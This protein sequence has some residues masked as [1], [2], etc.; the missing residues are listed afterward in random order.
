[1]TIDAYEKATTL[2]SEIENAKENLAYRERLADFFCEDDN[3]SIRLGPH[4]AIAVS[5][6]IA[7]EVLAKETAKIEAKIAELEAEFAAL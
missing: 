4:G 1:M 2:L 7:R 5:N 6:D 3:A